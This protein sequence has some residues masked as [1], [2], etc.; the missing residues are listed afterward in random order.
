MN[1]LPRKFV[2]ARTYGKDAAWSMW[3]L[4][5]ESVD[6]LRTRYTCYMP[7]L[8]AAYGLRVLFGG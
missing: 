6:L 5:D 8:W 1:T 2:F 3:K 7:N 4:E